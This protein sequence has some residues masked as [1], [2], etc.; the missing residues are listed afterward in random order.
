MNNNTAKTS[1]SYNLTI[2]DTLPYQ[3]VGLRTKEATIYIKAMYI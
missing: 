3:I 1:K 2:H